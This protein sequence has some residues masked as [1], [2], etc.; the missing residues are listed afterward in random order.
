MPKTVLTRANGVDFPSSKLNQN[1]E[2]VFCLS[3]VRRLISMKRALSSLKIVK[4]KPCQPAPRHYRSR[5]T[6]LKFIYLTKSLL[7]ETKTKVIA[8]R[9]RT[10]FI[11]QS[12]FTVKLCHRSRFSANSFVVIDRLG[13]SNSFESFPFASKTDEFFFLK[14]LIRLRFAKYASLQCILQSTILVKL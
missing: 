6:H 14:R 10:H 5:E 8:S 3:R 13:S 4:K 11:I 12:F 2:Y 9:A 7:H 1:N